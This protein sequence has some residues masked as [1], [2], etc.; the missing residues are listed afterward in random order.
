MKQET[1]LPRKEPPKGMGEFIK[2]SNLRFGK[3]AKKWGLDDSMKNSDVNAFEN[4]YKYWN[5]YLIKGKLPSYKWLID[6]VFKQNHFTANI[7]MATKELGI[8]QFYSKEFVHHLANTIRSV[9]PAKI[10]EIGAGDGMLSHFLLQEEGIDIVATDSKIRDDIVYPESVIKLNHKKALDR[11][12]PDVVLI[13]WEEYRKSYS[14]DVLNYPSVRC[15]IWIGEGEGGCTGSDKLWEYEHTDND[16]PY[17]LCRTD[18]MWMK[19]TVHK[20]TGVWVFY[21]KKSK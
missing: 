8:F 21:P 14:V 12:R 16:N 13:N 11:Y 20:H 1:I 2:K 6:N 9:K 7:F 4:L 17:C 5:N 18:D 19:N 3:E 15:I 10:I